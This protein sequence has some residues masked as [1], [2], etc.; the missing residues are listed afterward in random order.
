MSFWKELSRR[1]VVKVG[2]A[3]AVAAWL[4]I[5]PVDIIF[6]TLH[7]PEWTTTFVTALF[8]IAFPFVLLFSW[9]Y[10]I[11]PKGLKKTKDVPISK[12][13]TH[14]TGKRLN[15]I[16]VGLLVLAVA[17]LLFD[18]YFI[19]RSAVETKQVPVIGEVVKTQK[20]IAVLPFVNMSSDKEQEYFVDGLSEEILNS[21]CQIPDLNV[22]AKTSSFSF[23]KTTKT[24][25]EI[26]Q[27]LGVEHILEGSVRK[28][29]NELRITAQLV[30]ATDGGHLWSKT[31]DKEL[32]DIFAV[33]EDIASVVASELKATLE[34]GK[35]L[36]QLGGTD[37]TEAY[38][39]YLIANGQTLDTLASA[40][41]AM[42]SIDKA[43]K[44]DPQFALAWAYKAF[45]HYRLSIIGPAKQNASEKDAGI[46]AV[47][48]ALELEPNLAI[49]Y[50][51]LCA[52][53]WSKGDFIEAHKAYLKALDLVTEPSLHHEV[54]SPLYYFSLGYC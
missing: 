40:N 20:T 29:G 35:S 46:N 38:T 37:N 4:I 16:I 33:Q 15:Y 12:S 9:I 6:P 43:I 17:Y 14:I 25:Q 41:R 24:I 42:E 27:V 32:K 18:K 23:K 47:Q 31:Y 49:G 28:A 30:R 44:I 48:K 11:T 26:A 53:K 36:K 51:Y 5:H 8:I 3:Y 54:E 22:I 1:N 45:C 39:F 34:V 52:I 7:L 21:L 50:A 19:G 10:E 2:I 13:I